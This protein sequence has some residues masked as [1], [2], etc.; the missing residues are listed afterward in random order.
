MT[1]NQEVFDAARA[2]IPGGVNS[3]VRGFGSSGWHTTAMVKATGPYLT[4]IEGKTYVDLVGSWGPMLLGHNHPAVVDA[5][6]K[7]V[8][9]GL[10]FGTSVARRNPLG[11]ADRQN[12]AG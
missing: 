6:H 11:R 2:I 9:D 5:V 4:D 7:A 10:S 12:S 1:T 8:D 3:P